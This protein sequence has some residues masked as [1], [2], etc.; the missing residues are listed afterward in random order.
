MKAG[1]L[2]KSC[3]GIVRSKGGGWVELKEVS[4]KDFHMLKKT[5]GIGILESS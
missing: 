3:T 1:F 5:Y 4:K 2:L